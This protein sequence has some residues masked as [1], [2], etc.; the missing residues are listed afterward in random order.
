VIGVSAWQ[1]QSQSRRLIFARQA[2]LAAALGATVGGACLY[3]YAAL[4]SY[5]QAVPT[6][7]ERTF[8]IYRCHNRCRFGGYFV[9]QRANGTTVEGEYAGR[10]LAYGRCTTVQQLI[11]DY[12]FTW[13]RV[14]E[15]S[16]SGGHEINW[17]IRREDCFS[18]KPMSSLR[19]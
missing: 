19:A 16:R 14:I 9:H 3:P 15:R 10:R 1:L 6:L 18:T 7:R 5:A 13:V 11:G 17:P 12:G 4:T 2:A 8:E